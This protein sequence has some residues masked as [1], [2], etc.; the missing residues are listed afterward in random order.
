MGDLSVPLCT[1][2]HQVQ[3]LFFPS[4]FTDLSPEPPSIST[5]MSF[6]VPGNVLQPPLVF[7]LHPS[8]NSLV[9]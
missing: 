9:S 5:S 1:G 6:P 3:L 2:M 7:L 4:V 8:L